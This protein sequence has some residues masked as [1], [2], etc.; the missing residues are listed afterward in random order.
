VL[1]E[2]YSGVTLSSY[3]AIVVCVCVC[4][5]HRWTCAKESS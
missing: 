1:E 2:N 3:H 4:S 5:F